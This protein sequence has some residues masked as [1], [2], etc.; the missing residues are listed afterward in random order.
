LTPISYQPRAVE[1]VADLLRGQRPVTLDFESWQLGELLNAV[2]NRLDL[3]EEQLLAN[4]Q[5]VQA[6]NGLPP[7]EMR[8]WIS[9][10][11]RTAFRGRP[12]RQLPRR[13]VGRRL[14]VSGI[15]PFGAGK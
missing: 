2:S 4:L 13:H 1:A 14:A 6:R 10:M 3:S 8:L 7:D 9:P 15:C 11:R 12:R 5:T